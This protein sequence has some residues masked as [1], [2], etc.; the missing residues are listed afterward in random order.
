M[1]RIGHDSNIVVNIG[2]ALNYLA[3]YLGECSVS[4]LRRRLNCKIHAH[5]VD[6]V[7]TLLSAIPAHA[8]YRL[9]NEAI[10]DTVSHASTKLFVA[11]LHQEVAYRREAIAQVVLADIIGV[12][13]STISKWDSYDEVRLLLKL[14]RLA[15]ETTEG[16]SLL[17]CAFK[18]N[19]SHQIEKMPHKRYAI[20]S[21]LNPNGLIFICGS[22]EAEKTVYALAPMVKAYLRNAPKATGL[23]IG[24]GTEELHRLLPHGTNVKKQINTSALFAPSVLN[25]ALQHLRRANPELSGSEF[26]YNELFNILK[27]VGTERDPIKAA[28]ERLCDGAT[29]S[30]DVSAVLMGLLYNH[31][32][33]KSKFSEIV[34]NDAP[35]VEEFVKESLLVA[36]ELMASDIL[37]HMITAAFVE[38]HPKQ[39]TNGYLLVL[40]E[41]GAGK[42]GR[43]A[44]ANGDSFDAF[45]MSNAP[46]F[47]LD[48][49]PSRTD[50]SCTRILLRQST[51]SNAEELVG[52]D[53]ASILARL[54]FGEALIMAPRY[55]GPAF[56]PLAP[57]A[58]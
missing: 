6:A 56:I 8:G 33:P 16:K 51:E 34:S 15:R 19:A 55:K 35:G 31:F 58:A 32:G 44:C 1:K 30:P 2:K 11:A 49:E 9:L 20:E 5:E 27:C 14:L 29:Y 40:G 3:D 45:S 10:R 41:V 37:T 18:G 38:T 26:F 4:A 12:S 57:I 53:D 24:N 28:Q 42:Y 7:M 52:K 48:R 43:D 46:V 47:I 17:T 13:P 36:H 54:P 39:P 21:V 22:V 50:C 23:F 25:R